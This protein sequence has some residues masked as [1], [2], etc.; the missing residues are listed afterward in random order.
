MPIKI[1]WGPPG[2]YK[3][4]A[5]VWDEVAQCAKEGR[6][7]ITNIRGLNVGAIREHFPEVAPTFTMDHFRN[8]DIEQLNNLRRWWHW[9]PPGAY[10]VLDEVQHVYPPAWTQKQLQTLDNPDDRVI[11][12]NGI[13]KDLAGAFDMHRHGNWDLAFTTP[14]IKKVIPE[15]RMT[16]EG[17]YKHRNLAF[18]GLSGRFLQCQHAAEDNGNP[19]DFYSKRMRRIPQWVFKCYESTATGQVR[20]SA[21][22]LSM[23]KN[24]R[25]L[26]I[27]GLLGV[28]GALILNRPIPKIAGGNGAQISELAIPRPAPS[29]P[30]AGGLVPVAQ[31]S[32]QPQR[33]HSL[34]GS[35]GPDDHRPFRVIAVVQGIAHPYAVLTDGTITKRFPLN[36][37]HRTTYDGWKC[38]DDVQPSGWTAYDVEEPQRS[39]WASALVPMAGS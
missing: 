22:G 33:S 25:V 13:P 26:L 23:F 29:N 34:T 24:P 12:G 36:K 21:A 8:D 11:N 15:I 10:I 5:A 14:N 31:G 30:S 7:L 17:A 4:A 19:S 20:D 27:L 37:C 6:H 35:T 32:G 3:S 38:G 39:G 16:A 2:S 28:V 18:V 1:F 9:A